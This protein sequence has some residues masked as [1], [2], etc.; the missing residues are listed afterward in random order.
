MNVTGWRCLTCGDRLG[1]DAVLPWRCPSAGDSRH[2]V[3]AI[4][5]SLAPLRPTNDDNPFLAFDA[6]LAWAAFADAHGMDLAARA[7]LVAELDAAVAEVCGTGFRRTPFTRRKRL[8]DALG[9]AD[10]GGVWVKDETGNVAGSHKARH[11]F[12]IL[13][14]LVAAERLGVAPW[15]D[16]RRPPLAISSCGNAAIAAATLARATDWPID[17]FI[18]EWASGVV[19]DTLTSL[20]ARL[21]RCPRV[22][23]DPPGDPCVLRF[24]EAVAAG[25]IP[26]SVQGPE[27]ALALDGGRTLFWEMYE[28]LGALLDRVF[29]QVGGGA[30]AACIASARTSAGV[31]PTFHAVQTEACAPLSRAWSLARAGGGARAAA[32]HW[33]EWMQPWEHVGTSAADGIL[34]DETYD[35]VPVLG[36]MADGGGSPVVVP[37]SLVLEAHELARSTTGANVSATGTAGLAGL[38]AIR[39]QI[40]DDERVVVIFSGV[41]R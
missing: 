26:F 6:E 21:H 30:L 23:T 25:A 22:P 9:F 28:V 41:E 40:A 18:P 20:G 19:V 33:D 31:H 17:V 8:S 39:D 16:A 5:R 36:A 37:E 4:E 12:S 2:H 14:H 10:E 34:D 24:R 35:W 27:N 29:V 32:A 1:I 7:A 13:L 11:L 38:M 3:L 15:H